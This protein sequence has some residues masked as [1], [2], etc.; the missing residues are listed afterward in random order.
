MFCNEGGQIRDRS[1]SRVLAAPGGKSTAFDFVQDI[2]ANQS[3]APQKSPSKKQPNTAPITVAPTSNVSAARAQQQNASTFM[4]D[5]QQNSAQYGGFFCQEGG[6]VRGRASSR[7]MAAPGGKSTAFDFIKDMNGQAPA[8]KQQQQQQGRQP[9]AVIQQRQQQVP[10]PAPIQQKSLAV[11]PPQ[12]KPLSENN[13]VTG[14]YTGMYC[15]EGG[16]VR[17]R[18]SSRVLAPPGGGS[19]IQFF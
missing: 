11:E 9:P 19:S 18:A 13:A 8:S 4:S 10:V 12:P 14:T 2:A 7:V 6:Q 16:Q 17:G 5:Q 15:T 3:A 1:S